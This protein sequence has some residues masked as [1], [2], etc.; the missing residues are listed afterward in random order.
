MWV[1]SLWMSSRSKGVMK[2]LC[3][4]ITASWVIL[5]ASFSAASMASMRA[6]REPTS[7]NSLIRPASSRLPTTMRSA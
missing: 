3:S 2:V 1:I 6:R 5:S 7:A 4:R